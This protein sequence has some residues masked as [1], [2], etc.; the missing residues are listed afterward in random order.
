MPPLLFKNIQARSSRVIPVL[1]NIAI[2]LSHAEINENYFRLV[3]NFQPN[4]PAAFIL[5]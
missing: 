5:R 1:V 2:F 4:C 3:A